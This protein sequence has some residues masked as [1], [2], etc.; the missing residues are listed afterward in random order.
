MSWRSSFRLFGQRFVSSK[1]LSS[2]SLFAT[3]LCVS[4][5]LLSGAVSLASEADVAFNPSPLQVE[6]P[7]GGRRKRC[8]WFL[9]RKKNFFKKSFSFEVVTQTD[10]PKIHDPNIEG[11][12]LVLFLFV[13]F[14]FKKKK[15]KL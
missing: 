6:A 3:S 15:K 1:S 4:G 12:S 11:F 9:F 8:C 14:F 2:K 7:Q 5:C 10:A 13:C